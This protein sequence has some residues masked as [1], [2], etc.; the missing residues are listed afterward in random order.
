MEDIL[1]KIMKDASATKHANIKQ[2]CLESQELLANQHGLMRS[3]PFEIRCKILET[4]RLA[5]ESKHGKLVSHALN[6]FQ[7][8]IWDKSFQ[9]VFE[10]EKEENWFPMQLLVAVESFNSQSDDVLLEILKILLN[11]TSTYGQSLSSRSIIMLISLCYDAYV[12]HAQGVK[13]AAQATI[14]QTLTSFCIMLQETDAGIEDQSDESDEEGGFNLVES[15]VEELY[16]VLHFTCEKLK[17]INQNHTKGDY[18]LLLQCILSILQ[19]IKIDVFESSQFINFVWQ[20]LSPL[21]V[22]LLGSPKT[23]K[24]IVS[25]HQ[26][27]EMN[28]IGRGSGCLAAAPSL[29]G[30]NA[31]TIYSIAI[32]LVRLTGSVGSLRPVLESLFHRMLLYP[33]VQHRL[34]ALKAVKELFS[35]PELLLQLAAPPLHATSDKDWIS[36]DLDLIK[37]AIDSLGECCHSSN[38]SVCYASVSCTLALLKSLEDISCGNKIKEELVACINSQFRTLESADYKGAKSERWL[39]T[40][41]RSLILAKEKKDLL[42]GKLKESESQKRDIAD[43]STLEKI[44]DEVAI[45]ESENLS[46]EENAPEPAKESN[47]ENMEVANSDRETTPESDMD[48]QVDF[49]SRENQLATNELGTPEIIISEDYD[50]EN[51]EA[52]ISEMKHSSNGAESVEKSDN[53]LDDNYENSMQYDKEG[54]QENTSDKSCKPET[55]LKENGYEGSSSKKLHL[56]SENDD[57]INSK[58]D[59]QLDI[60]NKDSSTDSHQLQDITSPVTESAEEALNYVSSSSSDDLSDD[61][62]ASF[63]NPM[64]DL[65]DEDDRLKKIP[66]TLLGHEDAGKEERERIERLCLARLEFAQQERQNARNFVNVLQSFLPDLLAIRSSIEADQALQ[67][68]SSK[69]CEGLWQSQQSIKDSSDEKEFSSHITILNADGIYLALYSALLLNLKLIRNDYYKEFSGQVPLTEQQFIEEVHGSGVLVYLSATWL[70]ELYQQIL[71]INLLEEAGYK[72]NSLENYALINLLSDV[73]GLGNSLPG[74]QQL[75]DFRRLEKA[76]INNQSS[77]NIEA[78][79]K[80]SRRILTCCWDTVLEVLSVLLNGTNSCGISSTVGFLLGTEGAKEEHRKTKDAIAESLDGLQRAAKLCNNLGLQS[81]CSAVFAQLAGASCPLSEDAIFPQIP[82]KFENR[83]FKKSLLSGRSKALRLHASQILSMDVILSKGLELGSHSPD[84]WKYVFQC[85]LFVL[86]LENM[87]FSGHGNTQSVTSRSAH[88]TQNQSTYSESHLTSLDSDSYEYLS[89]PGSTVPPKLEIKEIIKENHNFANTSD[90]IKDHQLLNSI[91]VLSQQ[92][93][94]LFEEAASRLNLHALITFL[95]ELCAAS[96]TQLFTQSYTRFSCTNSHGTNLLLYHLGDV[97][98]RCARGGRPLIH[99]MKAWSVVAPH[100]VEAACHKDSLIAKKGV[101]TIHD[102]VSALLSSNSELPHFHFNEALF[103]PFE[104]LLC[105]ELC[106]IDVQE[107]IVSSICEFVEGCTAEIHS[108]WRPLFGAL[109]TVQVPS[110]SNHYAETDMEREHLHHLRV[111]LDVFEAFLS[112]DNVF[113]FAYAAVDCLLC[114]LKHVKGPTELQDISDISCD[115]VDKPRVPLDMCLAALKYL[116]KCFDILSTMYKIPTCPVFNSAHRI[117]VYSVPDL[118]DPVIPGIQ[119][120]Y[121]E[122]PDSVSSDS[123]RM[124]SLRIEDIEEIKDI[125]NISRIDDVSVTL[126]SLEKHTGIIHVWFLLLEGLAGTLATCPKQYQSATME[127]LFNMLRNLKEVPGPEFG[128]YCVNHLLL[129]MLQNWLRRT[130][131]FYQVWDNFATNFKQC[132]GLATDL[133]V[134][135]IQYVSDT[136]PSKL[137]RGIGVNLMLEQLFLVLTE[138]VAQPM[139]IISRL[140][141]A[142]I[143]HTVVT[144]GECLTDEMWEIV[145]CNLRRACR[146]SLYSVKQLMVCFHIESDNFYGDIGEVKVAARRDCTVQESERLRQLAHQVFLLDC[147]QENNLILKSTCMEDDERSFTFLLFP[148]NHGPDDPDT[149]VLRVPFR[150]L[151]VSLLSHQILLQTLGSILLQ[152]TKYMLP[153]LMTLLPSENSTSSNGNKKPGFLSRLSNKQLCILFKCLEESYKT[154]CEFD[155]RPGLKFLIQKVAQT[156]VAANLYKQAGV[157]WTIHMVT[158]FELCMSSADLSLEFVKNNLLNEGKDSPESPKKN[159][160]EKSGNESTSANSNIDEFLML[161]NKFKDI[162]ETYTEHTIDKQGLPNIVDRMSDQ[163]IFFLAAPADDMNDFLFPSKQNE[164][165]NHQNESSLEMSSSQPCYDS[166]DSED[167]PNVKNEDSKDKIYT[168]ATENTINSL[169]SEYKKRKNQHSMPSKLTERVS[170]KLSSSS[171]QKSSDDLVPEDIINQRR[172]SIMK[173]GEAQ[174]QVFKQL[175][176]SFLDLHQSL[177]DDHFKAFL[178]VF[179]PGVQFL[180]AYTTDGELRIALSE[181]LQ[182]LAMCCDFYVDPRTVK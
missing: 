8:M 22:T 91:E 83:N 172:N 178:P 98:L 161:R 142:C 105:L 75:A 59:L 120:V 143:R 61:F 42:R 153:T 175:I 118:V 57:D 102:I 5:L 18:S 12:N 73:D 66:R 164:S 20:Q 165:Q 144:A 9:S 169:I 77:P 2:S 155:V 163:P 114:L 14:N 139:E 10:N 182:R 69:Y 7:R 119:I 92:L 81:C 86:Q 131:K 88:H 177:P 82:A 135:Y 151:V 138:C 52:I 65:L 55:V 181:W 6:G 79:R 115:S 104:N 108:G 13:T 134:D 173:D 168:L 109:R 137:S 4:L 80:F 49:V 63:D 32:E 107:Q 44:S 34:E 95:V 43:E 60:P 179:F 94:R 85:C 117:Q 35:K 99:V 30:V 133:V 26:N 96:Q 48:L 166:S 122:D 174:L 46:V 64:E 38:N 51:H 29:Q 67:E 37:I 110:I 145:C 171:K 1:A 136:S 156:N 68:F 70:A 31:K 54:M 148:P 90:V 154:A 146:V 27:S 78:G 121:F 106:D 11:M 167:L 76:V 28:E 147:Q 47:S 21:L 116:E 53:V 112:T 56:A 72:P 150:S 132:C 19:N 74:A 41:L 170:K 33:P 62:D 50:M 100:F 40:K 71:A 176:Q 93:D 158:I 129:P 113:V 23:D 45:P 126:Q 36:L 149:S 16:P 97:M 87:Y 24:N 17:D 124:S 15:V 140:G 89:M 39:K 130:T 3:P 58:F 103:K 101:S 128:I 180:V 123:G 125:N 159:L 157:S 25:S 141:C 160:E 84:C 111:V 152:G 162:C 127:A